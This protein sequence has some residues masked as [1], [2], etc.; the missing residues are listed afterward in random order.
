MSHHTLLPS[1]PASAERWLPVTIPGFEH[2]Y[3]VSDYGRVRSLPRRVA[4]ALVNSRN[5][6]YVRRGGILRSAP[7]SSGHLIVVLCDDTRRKTVPVH[8]LVADAFLGPRPAGCD[9]HHLN[10]IKADNRPENLA[11]VERSTHIAQHHQGTR[12]TSAKLT[13]AQVLEFR[14]LLAQ[15]EL[16]EHQIAA[17]YGVTQSNINSIKNGRTWRHLGEHE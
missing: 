17:M 10:G 3:E 6:Y 11:Y 5:G 2:L 1:A 4:S 14:V 15:G 8:R 16:S 12:T 9:T 7:D 13:A